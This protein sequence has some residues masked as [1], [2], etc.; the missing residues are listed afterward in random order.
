MRQQPSENPSSI[1]RFAC[2]D[3]RSAIAGT[4]EQ[5]MYCSTCHQQY[6]DSDGVWRFLTEP[7]QTAFGQFMSEYRI[8]R[9]HE[10]WG[11]D[12][13]EYYRALPRVPPDD[14]QRT[15]WSV[16]ART[17]RAL[18]ERVFDPMERVQLG[19]RKILDVGA[20]N[21]WLAYRLA[22]RGNHVAA[23]DLSLDRT[24]GLGAHA[25]YATKSRTVTL[26]QAE[27]DRL[28]FADGEA[29]I[30]VF[31]GSL[32]YSTDYGKTLR[33]AVRVLRPDGS[34]AIVD[35][36]VYRLAISGLRMVREREE[37]YERLHG[38]PSNAL[39]TENFLTWTRLEELG[40][41]LD[42][43]WHIMMPHLGPGFTL[44]RWKA[45]I[46]GRREPA[47]FPLIVGTPRPGKPSDRS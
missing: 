8:V 9:K 22:E 23:V 37:R 26:V 20:G 36:P 18:I 27:F 39:R 2:P 15:I 32:H 42:L 29:D 46:R 5:T 31:N 6:A 7:R 24:D 4:T 11:R 43:S 33:E 45:R 13:C 1:W 3:C 21:C 30:V 44:R 34:V 35:S 17:F 40:A 47:R 25:Y 38:F 28:P 14:P 16:R 10:G 19:P 12:D 41:N